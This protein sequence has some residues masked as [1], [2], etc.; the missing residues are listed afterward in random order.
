MADEKL[1]QEAKE[2]NQLLSDEGR[3]QQVATT[4]QSAE[5]PIREITVNSN[6]PASVG[7]GESVRPLR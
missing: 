7:N 6:C 4:P 2:L 3:A 5:R 1:V